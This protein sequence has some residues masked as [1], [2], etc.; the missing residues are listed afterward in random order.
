MIANNAPAHVDL[1]NG[2][3]VAEVF[4]WDDDGHPMILTPSGLA[5]ADAVGQ[6]AIVKPGWDTRIW[7]R[8]NTHRVAQLVPAPIE[9][10]RSDEIVAFA[11]CDHGCVHALTYGGGG[12]LTTFRGYRMPGN[13]DGEGEA[14]DVA[15][16]SD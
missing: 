7:P 3:P 13:H 16:Q 11:V 5:R 10:Y 1:G 6:T 15:P 2:D 12:L 9:L 14:D 8:P 4:A